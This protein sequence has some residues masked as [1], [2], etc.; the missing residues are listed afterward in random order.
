MNDINVTSLV[1]RYADS[2]AF[3]WEQ[4]YCQ[5]SLEFGTGVLASYERVEAELFNAAIAPDCKLDV[6]FFFR[7]EACTYLRVVPRS[8]SWNLARI[9]L[10]D[11]PLRFEGDSRWVRADDGDIVLFERVVNIFGDSGSHE[12]VELCF[13]HIEGA[14]AS[15]GL[16]KK[17]PIRDL[18]FF[19]PGGFDLDVDSSRF[20]DESTLSSRIKKLV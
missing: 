2:L 1:R 13:H 7:S 19:V 20:I 9:V 8:G 5:A 12:L 6:S 18:E 17:Y 14:D 11:E 10:A 3:I 15:L 16:L 4:L